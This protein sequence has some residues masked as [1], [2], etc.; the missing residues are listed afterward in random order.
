MRRI[1]QPRL[2]Q[3]RR[4]Q[5]RNPL[6]PRSPQLP[7]NPRRRRLTRPLPSNGFPPPGAVGDSRSYRPV[8]AHIPGNS[9][10]DGFRRSPGFA[11]T[12][13]FVRVLFWFTLHVLISASFCFFLLLAASFPRS[14]YF[15]WMCRTPSFFVLAPAFC[16]LSGFCAVPVAPVPEPLQQ[17]LMILQPPRARFL[18]E[19]RLFYSTE[20]FIG[21]LN[22]K[23]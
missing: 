13:F 7:R 12:P 10:I 16:L 11:G 15:P 19:N 3:P 21:R 23:H 1:P 5:R 2:L 4:Q 8:A 22:V 6:P 18:Q 17:K 20:W 14:G 9:N